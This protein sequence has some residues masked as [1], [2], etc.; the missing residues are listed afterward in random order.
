[1][2]ELQS[3]DA[4]EVV[5]DAMLLSDILVGMLTPFYK[6]ERTVLVASPKA[7]ILHYLKSS[8]ALD[9]LVGFPLDFALRLSNEHGLWQLLRVVQFLRL[10][11]CRRTVQSLRAFRLTK[12]VVHKSDLGP[13]LRILE[14]L[15][16]IL[17]VWHWLACLWWV[18]GAI[19]WTIRAIWAIRVG[20]GWPASGGSCASHVHV[21]GYVHAMGPWSWPASGGSQRLTRCMLY[22]CMPGQ[23]GLGDRG[24]HDACCAHACLAK[25]GL[26]DRGSHDACCAHACL[27]K[28]GLG[29]RGS[30]DAC[31]AHAFAH[32]HAYN[33]PA[34]TRFVHRVCCRWFILLRDGSG[35]ILP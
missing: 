2:P 34:E 25:E 35:P 3:W 20:T 31:C 18:I 4:C 33:A 21:H 17:L 19:N 9:L 5:V 12:L 14:L 7:V 10:A 32:V 30:H 23:E 22:T 16:V 8:L 6:D 15:C 24:S 28:E 26:G 13:L 27:A 29:H 1:M 11:K